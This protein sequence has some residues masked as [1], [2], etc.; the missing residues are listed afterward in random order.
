M[1][2]RGKVLGRDINIEVISIQVEGRTVDLKKLPEESKA[3]P[4][5]PKEYRHL[6][7]GVERTHQR[8]KR[9]MW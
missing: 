2:L 6:N 7:V 8:R 1:E 3:R 4:K 5:D 9:V